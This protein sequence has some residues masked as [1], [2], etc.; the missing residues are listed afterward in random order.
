MQGLWVV[1]ATR[2]IGSIVRAIILDL[3]EADVQPL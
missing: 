2:I 3:Y 1:T